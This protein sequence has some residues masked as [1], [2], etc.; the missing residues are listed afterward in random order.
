MTN[1]DTIGWRLSHALTIRQ[2]NAAELA[3]RAGYSKATISLIR[4]NDNT[5]RIPVVRDLAQVLQISPGWLAFGE[6]DM[7]Q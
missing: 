3:R 5:P 2:I 7:I 6:G 1:Q 4:S